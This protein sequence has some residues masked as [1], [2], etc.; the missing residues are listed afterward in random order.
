MFIRS[1]GQQHLARE[2]NCLQNIIQFHRKLNFTVEL[3]SALE[4]VLPPWQRKHLHTVSCCE[5][6]RGP[7]SLAL[8]HRKAAGSLPPQHL[9]LLQQGRTEVPDIRLTV[10]VLQ[11]VE[12]V[13]RHLLY[14]VVRDANLGHVVGKET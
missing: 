1:K 5:G 12:I 10:Q 2:I 14:A 13:T 11:L 8:A 7:G 3:D 9:Q 6:S 4:H